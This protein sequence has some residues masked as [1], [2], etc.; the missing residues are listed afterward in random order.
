MHKKLILSAITIIIVI[1]LIFLFL[2]NYK[3]KTTIPVATSVSSNLTVNAA[4]SDISVTS[5]DG[6]SALTMK[7]ETAKSIV[8][9]TFTTDNLIYT[10]TTSISD[11]FSIPFNTW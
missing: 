4:N 6:K 5:P 2:N 1:I 10:K 8:I 7:K 11:N 3:N 9:Y